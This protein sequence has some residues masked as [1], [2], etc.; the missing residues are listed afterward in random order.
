MVSGGL[1]LPVLPAYLAS[2][3]T[4]AALACSVKA[5]KKAAMS[6]GAVAS[7]TAAPKLKAVL[8]KKAEIPAAAPAPAV[9]AKLS[10]ENSTSSTTSTVGSLSGGS[11]GGGGGN[12]VRANVRSRLTKLLAASDPAA[13]SAAGDG[14]GGGAG[15]SPADVAAEI[16]QAMLN[17]FMSTDKDYKAKF[18]MLSSNLKANP[19]LRQSMI[20]GGIEAAQLVTMK[21]TELAKDEVRQAKEKIMKDAADA[22]RSDWEQA[23]EKSINAACGISQVGGLYKCGACKS[24]KTTHYSQQT[25]SADEP[26]TVFV[27][28]LDC[29]KKW[30]C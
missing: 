1:L 30:K 22:A 18:R 13:S 6:E 5:W 7:P 2:L 28:C 26:M 29:G 9:T 3:L 17:R 14:G 12:D 19:K 20:L 27:S 16:E 10:R 11:G 25:R 23:N 4:V 24:T 15:R 8:Y 21:P